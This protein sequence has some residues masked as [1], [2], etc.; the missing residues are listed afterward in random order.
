[1][2]VESYANDATTT[3]NGSITAVATT[4]TVTSAT[5]FPSSGQYRITINDEIML[6]TAGHGTTSWTVTRAQEG[7]TGAVHSSGA[8]VE[9]RLTKAALEAVRRRTATLTVA[10]AAASDAMKASADYVCDG[11][12]DQVE[13]N[14]AIAALPTL[15]GT[16]VLS[17]GDFNVTSSILIQNE[18]V[19]LAGQGAGLYSGGSQTPSTGTRIDAV[20][21]V[22]SAVI[23]VQRALN[24]RP[25]YGVTIRDLAVDGSYVGTAVDGILF[26]SNRG[27]IQHVQVSRCSGNGVVI[28]GYSSWATYDTQ[29]IAVQAYSNTDNG[30]QTDTRGEDLHFIGCLAFG[31]GDCGIRNEGA[32]QQ[33]VN[34]HSY[35]NDGYGF[36]FPGSGTRSKISNAKIEGNNGGVYIE[37]GASHI[38]ITGCGFKDNSR[39]TGNTYDHINIAG[40]SGSNLN[41]VTG[42]NFVST[43]SNKARYGVNLVNTNATNTLITA[44]SFADGGFGTAPINNSGA[45]AS[46]YRAI[47]RNNLGVA[48]ERA[49]TATIPS[50]A[51]KYVD[52]TH[53]LAW[54]P[55]AHE[56]SVVG[57]NL[58][59]NAIGHVYLTNLGATTFRINCTNDPGA[60]TATFSWAARL[61]TEIA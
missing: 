11:T 34:T 2:A 22:T 15:G 23:L 26:R 18:T 30:F 46:G 40:S 39:T 38:L 53:G 54:T 41:V 7:T 32:S 25:V 49:G 55:R 16:V 42:C 45:T 13:I 36:Y 20:T 4:I 43:I 60:S 28:R 9:H 6:V 14:A 56:I 37:G 35:D 12:A 1:M 5:G 17:E 19:T 59:T 58:P 51:T 3:L 61:L 57:T 27:L 47:I 8:A 21:G 24:D 33:F 48:T 31:N 50:G 44:N 52:V 29:L 10:S